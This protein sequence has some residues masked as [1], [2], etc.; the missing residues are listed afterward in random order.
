MAS[1]QCCWGVMRI[2]N[3]LI[4]NHRNYGL[5]SKLLTNDSFL[6][7][8]FLIEQQESKINS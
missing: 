7:N 6:Y 2:I 5:I 1:D 3:I 8:F 4:L